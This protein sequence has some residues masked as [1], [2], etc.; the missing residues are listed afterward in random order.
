MQPNQTTIPAL[1]VPHVRPLCPNR[2]PL[3]PCRASLSPCTANAV[4]TLLLCPYPCRAN[5]AAVPIPTPMP[6]QLTCGGCAHAENQQNAGCASESVC[7]S[8]ERV[9]TLNVVDWCRR[10]RTP[11]RRL[12]LAARH[13]RRLGLAARQLRLEAREEHTVR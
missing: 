7:G 11:R 2:T 13:R 3:C 1:L 4:P 5:S 6:C 9:V 10:L 8:G 12:G